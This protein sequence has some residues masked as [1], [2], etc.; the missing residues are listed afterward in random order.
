MNTNAQTLPVQQ[1]NTND[2]GTMRNNIDGDSAVQRL[3]KPANQN[4]P[5]QQGAPADNATIVLDSFVDGLDT[6]FREA[7]SNQRISGDNALIAQAQKEAREAL[8]A[9]LTGNNLMR[10]S[11]EQMVKMQGEIHTIC[12]EIAH[13]ALGLVSAATVS[14]SH[15]Q[16]SKRP[17][18]DIHLA[19]RDRINTKIDAFHFKHLGHAA[20]IDA[21]EK[22]IASSKQHPQ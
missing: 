19:L 10:I 14:P 18:A 21:E 16:T 9:L 7:F 8:N 5:P 2:L 3:Q 20:K 4:T 11:P 13:E 6:A 15:N 12:N 17:P 22:T 1:A